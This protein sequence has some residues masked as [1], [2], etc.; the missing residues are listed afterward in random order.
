MDAAKLLLQISGEPEHW[1]NAGEATTR[2]SS[3]GS[4][5]TQSDALRYLDLFHANELIVVGSDK[6][7]QFRPARESI[8]VQVRTLAQAYK[9]RPV[10][11]F[12]VIYALRDRQES[13]QSAI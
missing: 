7:M 9:E 13:N 2:V 8:A 3:A 4:S 5:I 6:R 12:R 10:T 1:W 11:L